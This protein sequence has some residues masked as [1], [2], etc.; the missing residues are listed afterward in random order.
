MPLP[1]DSFYPPHPQGAIPP[2][3]ASLQLIVCAACTVLTPLSATLFSGMG[4]LSSINVYK[5]LVREWAIDPSLLLSPSPRPKLLSLSPPS[6]PL[7]KTARHAAHS[8]RPIHPHLL[9]VLVSLLPL[10]PP[11][12]LPFP[13]AVFVLPPGSATSP[14]C[15]DSVAARTVSSTQIRPS[16]SPRGSFDAR[17]RRESGTSTDACR[18]ASCP[19]R[20]AALSKR[21]CPFTRSFTSSTRSTRRDILQR[22]N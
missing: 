8:A 3:A 18:D 13:R 12:S 22:K 17:A 6:T 19:A 11:L 4:I 9:P 21:A 14:A 20:A 5:A 2:W 7:S 15:D 10:L 1:R 16:A